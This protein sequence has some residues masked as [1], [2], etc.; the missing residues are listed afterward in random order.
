MSQFAVYFLSSL[1]FGYALLHEPRLIAQ[2]RLLTKDIQH[3]SDLI[4]KAEQY[5]ETEQLDKAIAS[6]SKILRL[7]PQNTVARIR[8]G[9]C[10]YR[11]G[12]FSDSY[13]VLKAVSL[14]ILDA[15]TRYEF[16][17][18]AFKSKKYKHSLKIFM[19]LKENHPFYDLANFY[20]ALSAARIGEYKLG[21][22]LMQNAVALP[23]KLIPTKQKV[24]T[25][26]R[27]L[28]DKQPTKELPPKK[29]PSKKSSTL[30]KQ[31]TKNL[32]ATNTLPRINFYSY[33]IGKPENSSA[34][35]ANYQMQG[36]D[37]ST[38]NKDISFVQAFADL[39]IQNNDNQQSL[40]NPL[41]YWA[42][43]RLNGYNE[44]QKYFSIFPEDF[45][46]LEEQIRFKA[47]QSDDSIISTFVG[48]GI[49]PSWQLSPSL[50]LILGGELLA[51]NQSFEGKATLADII[52]LSSLVWK[53][54]SF[55]AKLTTEW[56]HRQ[57]TEQSLQD[58]F[59]AQILAFFET[60]TNMDITVG[61]LPAFYNYIA[62][63]L[64][65]PSSEVRVFSK[66][67]INFSPNLIFTLNGHVEYFFQQRLH[68]QLDTIALE[69]DQNNIGAEA[70][71]TLSYGE[72]LSASLSA[73]IEQRFL[74][75]F[76]NTS[77]EPL[78]TVVP[79]TIQAIKAQASINF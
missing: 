71:V 79:K 55:T 24:E 58:K 62:D 72:L 47:E 19:T 66:A 4:K 50:W 8:L 78:H 1:Y 40:K 67:D 48:G 17:L 44:Q 7:D 9:K 77:E 75:N 6:Y 31:Q 34:I 51:V 26:L 46:N 63:N 16:G 45:E 65:G 49:A 36:L 35:G 13:L 42:K 74:A 32:L 41:T 37:Y 56:L 64:D 27:K 3:I 33:T 52:L 53:N 73:N 11:Q 10:F 38:E 2:T 20:G 5:Y 22:K 23:S 30:Q 14:E 39:N 43:F 70:S 29:E 57:D 12:L 59:R 69:F 21:L 15:D 18:S 25:Q 61:I 76:I 54:L 60:S 28:T 68:G